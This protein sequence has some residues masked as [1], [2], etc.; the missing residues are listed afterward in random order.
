MKKVPYAEIIFGRWATRSKKFLVDIEYDGTSFDEITFVDDDESSEKLFV[1]LI[2]Y[3]IISYL[4]SL[5]KKKSIATCIRDI[6]WATSEEE[7]DPHSK[8]FADPNLR[9]D[10]KRKRA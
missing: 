8:K 1:P 7:W 2:L 10:G 4:G 9:V 6:F 3:G 5:P